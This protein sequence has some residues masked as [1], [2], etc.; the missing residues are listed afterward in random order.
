V[1]ADVNGKPVQARRNLNAERDAEREL[2]AKCPV[3][4]SP[5]AI[6]MNGCWASR[7]CACNC[8]W[9]CRS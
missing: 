2:I 1:I 6:M 7:R 8:W 9:N 5:S 3:L 4:E